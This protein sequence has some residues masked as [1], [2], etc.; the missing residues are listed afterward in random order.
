MKPL[1][2]LDAPVPGEIVHTC[3]IGRDRYHYDF[4]PCRGW[5]Q[6]DTSA[7]AWYFGHWACPRKKQLISFAEG[8]ETITTCDTIEDWVEVVKDWFALCVRIGY[9]P[10]VD[11]GLEPE[12]IEIWEDLG[13]TNEKLNAEFC[14]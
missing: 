2:P 5:A 6:L 3:Y 10:S 4:G 14:E 7:D 9:K 12:Y 8:D 13:L 11:P 1:K